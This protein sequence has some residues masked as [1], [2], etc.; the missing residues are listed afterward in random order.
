MFERFTE[1]ARKV[2]VLAQEEARHF[3]H[4]YIGTEHLLLGLLRDE[5]SAASKTLAGFGIELDGAR[6]QVESIVG[7]GEGGAYGQAPFTPRCKKVLEMASMEALQLGHNYVGTEHILLGL[8]RE[9]RGVA[10][11]VLAALDLDTNA[12]HRRLLRDIGGEAREEPEQEEFRARVGPVKVKA[13]FGD[14]FGPLF[15]QRGTGRLLVELDY[16]YSVSK[17]GGASAERLDHGSLD[18]YVRR[19]VA[20]GKFESLEAVAAEVG[21]YALA[22]F[23]TV[24][25]ITVSV[26]GRR[27]PAVTVTRTFNR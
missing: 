6:D 5:D 24:R 16:I 19:V 15:E 10:N 21:G 17:P 26:A 1:R 2:V 13:C 7:Y 14:G 8:L 22:R 9:G 18:D 27:A 12:L 20:V 23:P 4:G 11:R 3:K 25:R